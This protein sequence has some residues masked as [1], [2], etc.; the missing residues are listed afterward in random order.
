MWYKIKKVLIW[1]GWVEKQIYPAEKVY[2]FDFQNNWQLGW[3]WATT[4]WTYW[5]TAWQW[6]YQYSYSAWNST[7][8]KIP[9][10]I[11]WKLK[12]IEIRHTRPDIISAIWVS[13]SSSNVN[14]LIRVWDRNSNVILYTNWWTLTTTW[15]NIPT[16]ELYSVFELWDNG[17]ISW[18]C[19]TQSWTF[20][21]S[22]LST[23]LATAVND[24]SFFLEFTSFG[25]S[26]AQYVRK[27]QITMW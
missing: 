12:K 13:A 1:Q 19:N 10:W 21:A 3:T 17:N 20:T 6:F 15:S 11:S 26:N 22:T 5:Y 16:W 18:T 23:A 27:I 14:N 25:S 4:S 8:L 2:T 24:G 9:T 7:Y